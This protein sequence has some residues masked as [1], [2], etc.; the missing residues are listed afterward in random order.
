MLSGHYLSRSK[1]Q[2][3]MREQGIAPHSFEAHTLL[4]SLPATVRYFNVVGYLCTHADSALGQ[5]S[6]CEIHHDRGEL[7][8]ET[9]DAPFRFCSPIVASAIAE[10]SRSLLGRI[11]D[12]AL[13]VSVEERTPLFIRH[14]GA[15]LLICC[16]PMDQL[17]RRVKHKLWS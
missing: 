6:G 2:S 11:I 13:D 3:S 12:P 8:N 17:K 5:T 7:G 9:E 14:F 1:I 10:D 16:C 15:R 4:E